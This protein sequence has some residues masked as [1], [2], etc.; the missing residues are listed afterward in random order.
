M[1]RKSDESGIR[2]KDVYILETYSGIRI[3]IHCRVVP[4]SLF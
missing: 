4:I 1:Y 2:S 3:M